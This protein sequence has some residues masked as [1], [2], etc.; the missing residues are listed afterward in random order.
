MVGDPSGR[1]DMRNMMSKETIEHNCECFKKQMSRF[2]EFGEDKALMVNNGDW[3]LD[4]NYIEFIRDIGVHFS[5]TPPPISAMGRFPAICIR[6]I[7]H[8]AIKCPTWRLSAVG[9]KPM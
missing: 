5:V 3:L 7:R 2:I 1:S 6:F 8:R 9:S 4:L